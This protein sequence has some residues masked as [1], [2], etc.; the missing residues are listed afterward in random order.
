MI[1]LPE[2]IQ[3]NVNL[4]NFQ[5]YTRVLM[6]KAL[7]FVCIKLFGCD[8]PHLEMSFNE[9]KKKFSGRS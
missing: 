7:K 1:R 2:T 5:F 9:V 3:K 4:T 6:T 8:V